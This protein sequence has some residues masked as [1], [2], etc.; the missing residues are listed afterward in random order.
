M[1]IKLP[2]ED[3]LPEGPVR[4]LVEVVHKLYRGAGTP[5]LRIIAKATRDGDYRDTASYETVG[6][7]LRGM[8]VVP[9]WSKLEAVVRV[10][11]EWHV[12]QLETEQQVAKILELWYRAQDGAPTSDSASPV[13]TF[14]PP[15]EPSPNEPSLD[16]VTNQQNDTWDHHVLAAL[17]PDRAADRVATVPPKTLAKKLTG[18]R[19][20]SN[21]EYDVSIPA[22]VN[23]ALVVNLVVRMPAAR[24]AKVVTEFDQALQVELIEAL[25]VDRACEILELI[26][27]GHAS[28]VLEKCESRKS[29]KVLEKM[30]YTRTA[31]FLVPMTLTHVGKL[32]SGMD[33]THV[34]GTMGYIDQDRLVA[35]LAELD[36]QMAASV[37]AAMDPTRAGELLSLLPGYRTKAV[38]D[39]AETDWLAQAL[40]TVSRNDA[41]AMLT[42]M[43]R[44]EHLASVLN[45]LSP[46][47][48]AAVLDHLDKK[49]ASATLSAMA[50]EHA[51]SVVPLVSRERAISLLSTVRFTNVHVIISAMGESGA[52]LG[53]HVRARRWWQREST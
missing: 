10:L 41:V 36:T 45:R 3:V 48:G 46:T 47:V 28:R 20:V 8:A 1:A 39:K 23:K 11:I 26:P 17:R 32:L 42:S 22:L 7:I 52:D 51:G 34:A 30:S 6:A 38:L 44:T 14:P 53:R 16:S 19:L 9:R 18:S 12:P 40:A 13:S 50:P 21:G 4:D 37:V 49:R 35:M 43:K 24:A 31:A 15:N 2:A 25:P 5:G 29:G 27:P 33:A